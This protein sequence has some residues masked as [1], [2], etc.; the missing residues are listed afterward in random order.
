MTAPD[1]EMGLAPGW[2]LQR[3]GRDLFLVDRHGVVGYAQ[4]VT[5]LSMVPAPFAYFWVHGSPAVKLTANLPTEQHE[6]VQK[7]VEE[8]AEDVGLWAT[9]RRAR[10]SSA[11]ESPGNACRRSVRSV[12]ARGS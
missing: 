11:W 2:F 10:G 5:A 12:G 4:Q 8:W 1:W 6:A 9:L 3:R 7:L